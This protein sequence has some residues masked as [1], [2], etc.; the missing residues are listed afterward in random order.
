LCLAKEGKKREAWMINKRRRREDGRIK[1]GDKE[2]KQGGAV[3]VAFDETV[4]G[5]KGAKNRGREVA[6]LDL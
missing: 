4:G 1:M 3:S 5:K 6:R 2:N